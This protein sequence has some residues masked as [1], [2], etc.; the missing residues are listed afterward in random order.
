M[1]K[2]RVGVI[3]ASAQGG[4]A[5]SAHIPALAALNE[6]E[7]TA[8]ATRGQA[9]ADGAAATFGARHAFAG[10]E[11]LAACPDVDLV[12][13]SVR[14]PHHAAAVDAAIRH[15][16]HVVCEWPLGANLGQTQAMERTAAEAGVRTFACLQ[17]R[18]APAAMHARDLLAA[19][20]VGRVLSAS[21]FGSFPFWGDPLFTAYGADVAS[22]A[23]V[24][25]IPGGHGLDLMRFLVGE[26][27]GLSGVESHLR[28]HVMASDIGALVPMSAPDQFAAIGTLAS[29]AVFSAHIVGAAARGQQFRLQIIGDKGELLIQA[30]GMPEIAELH[31]VGTRDRA[32]ASAPICVPEECEWV[33]KSLAGPALNIA[34]LYQLIAGDLNAGTHT[35]PSFTTGVQTRTL[36]DAIA[37]SAAERRTP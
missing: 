18:A 4:W 13:V 31:L 3:G 19:G 36:V 32:M 12:V 17:A 34:Q 29:G 1:K 35:A 9:S 22:G 6:F 10:A 11:A 5:R 16:K 33:P 20:Y 7:L 24:L 14:A 15:G 27:V 8:V 26:C 28:T 23:N 37:R 30:D 25:T 2:I 21:M